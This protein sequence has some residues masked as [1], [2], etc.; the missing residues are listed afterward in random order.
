MVADVGADNVTVHMDTY[1]MNIEEAS[2][3][4]AVKLCGD[5]LGR[6]HHHPCIH[7]AT[8]FSRLRMQYDSAQSIFTEAFC[9]IR[10]VWMALVPAAL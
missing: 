8:L 2:V 9:S 6:V 4:R 10:R 5:K 1:H 7:P 3:Q